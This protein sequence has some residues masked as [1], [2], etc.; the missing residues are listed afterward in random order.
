[1]SSNNSNSLKSQLEAKAAKVM[2]DAVARTVTNM[3]KGGTQ[4]KSKEETTTPSSLLHSTVPNTDS[5]IADKTSSNNS[6][7]LKSQ[8]EAKATKVVV[9]TVART[10]FGSNNTQPQQQQPRSEKE[11][12]KHFQVYIPQFQTT[13]SDFAD[14]MNSKKILGRLSPNPKQE[15]R[16]LWLEQSPAP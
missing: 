15:R 5:D 9:N 1:M 3:L 7:S 11:I 16:K 12:N 10:V 8:L 13:E 2:V 4:P 6:N 14:K